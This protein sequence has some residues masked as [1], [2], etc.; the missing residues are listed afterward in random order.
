MALTAQGWVITLTLV[1]EDLNETS[2]T[3]HSTAANYTDAAADSLTIATNLLAVSEGKISKKEIREQY[4]E[5]A[6]TPPTN[7]MPVSE[8]VSVTTLITGAGT[9]KANYT[10]P[11]PKDSIMSGNALV[12]SNSDFLTYHGMFQTGGLATISD[13]E[14]AGTV[15]KGVRVTHS[16]RFVA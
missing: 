14:I 7:D 1:D 2:K 11:M 13:G 12:T 15:V 9:K 16:R 10:I 5:T 4:E 8:A 3:Y 6:L